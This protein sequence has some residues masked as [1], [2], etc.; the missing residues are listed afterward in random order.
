VD[1]AH[2]PVARLLLLSLLLLAPALDDALAQGNVIRKPQGIFAVVNVQENV[3]FQ[4][5]LNP[6][7]TADQLESYFIGLY[8]SLFSNP[9]ISGVAIFEN[10]ERLNPNAPG[11]GNTYD[12]SYLDD[13]FAQ[14]AVWTAQNP[15]QPLKTI[16]LIPLPGFQ[17]PQWVMSQI[18]SCDGLF[19]TPVQTPSSA[20]GK[21][22]FTG[23]S[24]TAAGTELPLPWNSSYKSAWQ[25]FLIA[26]AAR[27]GS[28]PAFVSIAV[29]GPTASSEEM[30]LPAN[31]N[32]PLQSNGLLPNSMWSK[33][34]AFHYPG[35]A[36]YQ[37]TDQAFI[38]EWDN[39]IDMY[40][41]VFSGVTLVAPMTANGLPNFSSSY[42]IPPAF[43]AYCPTPTMHCAAATTVLS[44]FVQGAVGGA[45]AKATQTDGMEASRVGLNL[46]VGG[47]K[48][49]SQST[50]AD[51]TPST[52]ILGGAQFN[53]AFSNMNLTL[54]EGCTSTFPPDAGDTPAGC[55]VSSTCTAGSPDTCTIACIPQ[56]CLAPGVTTG[57]LAGYLDFADLEANDPA[58]LI[59]REQ[60]EYNVLQMFFGGTPAGP[61]WGGASGAAPLNYLQVYSTDFLYAASHLSAP[62]QV[63]ESG[64]ATVSVTAQTLLNQASQDLLQ[65]SELGAPT[66]IIVKSHN[67]VFTVS[68]QG[69]TYALNVSNVPGAGTTSGMVTV[70]ETVP[71]G[72]TLASMAGPGWTCPSGAATCTRSDARAAGM[73]Y[74]P[75]AVTVN[76]GANAPSSLT[77]QASVSGGGS[78]SVSASD[79]T[80]VLRFSPCDLNQDSITTVADVQLIL[81][82]AL[83]SAPAV[84]DLNQDGVV[85]VSDVQIVLNAALGLS[86]SG[87]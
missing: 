57:S 77:N 32:T 83:G 62:A 38:E 76:V 67:G 50:A 47:V 40:G 8:Q 51:T 42:T 63:V 66:L 11:G 13:A 71:T 58:A 1:G 17:S 5:S 7:I 28:N 36:A 41:Q 39:A 6:S 18:L 52:Q 78:F 44:Y 46:S 12:W 74:P 15:G 53:S 72:L 33:L 16:Q 59:P 35:M 34:L 3:N 24:E 86:C 23:F 25:T 80:I 54:Q 31:G 79:P 85:S 81:N 48:L 20:C 9:A 84:N 45:N 30:I 70:T 64:G 73:A 75:I 65:T 56:P 49:L 68:Q 82:Q 60:A 43:T 21:A 10:W 29:A 55:V 14:A 37:N 19:Q 2:V 4:Q 22:T 69:A 87:S 26:L 61:L 27:Y